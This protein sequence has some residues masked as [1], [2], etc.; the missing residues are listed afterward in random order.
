MISLLFYGVLFWLHK[1]GKNCC[2]G[3]EVSASECYTSTYTFCLI[4]WNLVWDILFNLL[5]SGFEGFSFQTI[6]QPIWLTKS[7]IEVQRL[8]VLL[9]VVFPISFNL[10]VFSSCINQSK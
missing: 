9:V 8:F 4:C 6:R 7:L 2:C 5:E 10:N 3:L 1:Q